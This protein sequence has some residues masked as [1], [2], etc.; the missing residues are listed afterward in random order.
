MSPHPPRLAQAL[1]RLLLRKEEASDLLGDLQERFAK[2]H[3]AH[4]ARRA[5]RWYWRQ[6]GG[7]A[8]RLAGWRLASAACRLI[9]APLRHLGLRHLG[10]Q[11]ASRPGRI[12]VRE[13]G[14]SLVAALTLALGIGVPTTMYSVVR[15]L[16]HDLPLPHPEQVVT[17]DRVDPRKGGPGLGW[18]RAGF[19]QLTSAGDVLSGVAAYRSGGYQLDGGGTAPRR[20]HGAAVTPNLFALLGVQPLLGRAFTAGEAAGG[21]TAVVLIREDL[22]RDAYGGSTEAL[23]R[24]VR[25]DGIERTIIGILPAW[26]GFPVDQQLWIPLAPSGPDVPVQVVGRLREGT[27]L[28]Q[29][30]AEVRGLVAAM[31]ETASADS[32][33]VGTVAPFT[34]SF[35]GTGRTARGLL[36]LLSFALLIAAANVSNLLLARAVARRKEVAVRRALGG[37]AADVILNVA[38]EAAVLAGLGSLGAVALSFAG[39]AWFRRFM[40]PFIHVWWVGFHVDR[41]VLGF[42]MIGGVAAA[43]IAGVAPAL[44]SVRTPLTRALQASTTE[45]R[46][47]VRFTRVSLALQVALSCALVA[48]TAQVIRAAIGGVSPEELDGAGVRVARLQP[49]PFDYPDATARGALVDRVAERLAATPGVTGVA[50]ASQLPG[51]SAPTE[52]VVPVSPASPADGVPSQL[53]RVS[54]S[55]FTL[56]RLERR[57]GRL[58]RD[59]DEPFTAAVVNQTLAER[60]GPDPVGRT[61][62]LPDAPSGLVVVGVVRDAGASVDPRGGAAPAVYLPM[63]RTPPPAFSLFVRGSDAVTAA[64][65]RGAVADVDPSLPV[66]DLELLSAALDRSRAVGRRFSTLLGA[67]GVVAT[68]M[69]LSGLYAVTAFSVSRRRRE[70]G[71][72]RALG[73]SATGIVGTVLRGVAL[74]LVLGLTA[75]VGL[76]VLARPVVAAFL[77]ARG[78]GGVFGLAVVPSLLAGAFLAAALVAARRAARVEPAVAMRPE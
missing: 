9:P 55:Y 42:A 59:D 58:L 64:A 19:S 67:F 68:L 72:R 20:V 56:F 21:E 43:L 33:V 78:G 66:E 41:R 25:V 6:A 18:S 57:A 27:S 47:S 22:W 15:G 8:P 11:G 38:G 10:T 1:L 37:S 4:G 75:G 3:A 28:E 69:A 29:A 50:F 53:R 70:I 23:G 30:K 46:R 31:D 62:R 32:A 44:Q 2:E 51:L 74:P 14:F 17:V 13:P 35:L 71:V 65:I 48:L 24:A 54:P 77:A 49:G 39:V 34:A 26:F 7:A 63:G 5:R 45:T 36:V 73:A 40:G 61:I 16:W 60:L 12:V 52:E 76:A